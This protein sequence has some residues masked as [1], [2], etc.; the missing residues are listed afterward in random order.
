MMTSR[1]P[2]VRTSSLPC[3]F[4]LAS[5]AVNANLLRQPGSQGA[6]P[7]CYADSIRSGPPLHESG[8]VARRLL[9]RSRDQRR[10]AR[11]G[12]QRRQVGVAFHVSR[13]L[14]AE[15][16]RRAERL[17]CPVPLASQRPAAG[18]VVGVVWAAVSCDQLG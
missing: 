10:P 4:P 18:S 2:N 17:E 16:D 15:I 12:P 6:R 8:A 14:E 7:P 13:L 1:S 11:L 5:V 9:A 3:L